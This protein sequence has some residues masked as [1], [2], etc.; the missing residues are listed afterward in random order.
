M[1]WYYEYNE[2]YD[3]ILFQILFYYSGELRI[4]FENFESGTD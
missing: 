3:I 2:Y 4:I 1:F